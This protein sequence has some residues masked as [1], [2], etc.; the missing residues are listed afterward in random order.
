MQSIKFIPLTHVLAERTSGD[1]DFIFGK[2]HDFLRYC[3]ALYAYIKAHNPKRVIVLASDRAVFLACTLVAFQQGIEVVLPHFKTPGVLADI[4]KENDLVLD[5]DLDLPEVTEIV[6]F[7]PIPTATLT[8]YTSG[9]TGQP[10]EIQKSLCQLQA[11]ISVLHTVWGQNISPKIWATVSHHH[12]YGLLFSLLWPVCAGYPIETQTVNFWEEIEGRVG[13]EDYIVS[14][15]AH[16]SRLGSLESLRCARVFSSG[17]PL[18][19]EAANTSSKV[20]GA[21]PYEVLGSTETGGIA[22]R[23]QTKPDQCWQTFPDVEVSVNATG[24][25]ILKSPYLPTQ[26]AYESAD[27]IN[28]LS[29]GKFVL[30]GRSDKVVKIEGKRLDLLDLEKRLSDLPTIEQALTVVFDEGR[31]KIGV[32]AILSDMG[33]QQFS[34]MGIEKFSRLLRADLSHYFER[35]LL[36][37]RWR[38]VDEFPRDSQGKRPSYLLKSLFERAVHD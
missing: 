27:R 25:L 21:L 5:D 26:E 30:L 1:W 7:I 16:L 22:Y 8:L 23:Q 28:L 29:P 37:R 36:P 13:I 31:S 34:E 10:K 33:R 18:S 12:I 6:P 19:F 3:T 35:V 32:V 15:P 14:S 4:V 2:D 20:F 9:S 17:A 38:F 11:E 24:N